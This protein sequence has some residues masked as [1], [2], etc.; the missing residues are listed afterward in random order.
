[1]KTYSLIKTKAGERKGTET[2]VFYGD[3]DADKKMLNEVENYL[4]LWIES[5]NNSLTTEETNELFNDFDGS[6][7][8]DVW[9]FNL[10]ENEN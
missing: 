10:E 6:F 5:Y 2:S 1:M 4:R 3:N 8:Y 7:S 9:T